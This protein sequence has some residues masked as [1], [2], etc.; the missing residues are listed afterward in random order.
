[1][2]VIVNQEKREDVID[3]DKIQIL[4]SVIGSLVISSGIHNNHSF[5]GIQIGNNRNME[6]KSNW[7]KS[8]FTLFKGT[9]TITQ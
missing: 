3:F 6:Y 8:N 9:I 7:Q 5:S 2:K 4:I 1:M